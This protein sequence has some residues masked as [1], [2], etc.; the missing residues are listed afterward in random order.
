V[1][2]AFLKLSI[3]YTPNLA[4]KLPAEEKYKLQRSQEYLEKEEEIEVLQ[5]NKN[6]DSNDR[7]KKLQRELNQLM[8]KALKKWQKEQPFRLDNPLLY[9]YGIFDRYRPMTPERGRLAINLF[10]RAKLRSSL[11]LLVLHDLMALL[12]KTSEVEFRPGLEKDKYICLKAEPQGDS[13]KI[14]RKYD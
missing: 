8:E 1:S 10:K 4:Q 6:A 14:P 12:K 9:H 3:P 5:G 11:G 2:E 7:I 13:H